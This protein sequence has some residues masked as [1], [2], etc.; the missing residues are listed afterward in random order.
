MNIVRTRT[1][2]KI[3][4]VCRTYVSVHMY[5]CMGDQSILEA[6]SQGGAEHRHGGLVVRLD[7]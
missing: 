1:R 5:M 7:D 6:G 4:Q 2:E 3:A